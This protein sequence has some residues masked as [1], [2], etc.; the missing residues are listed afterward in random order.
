MEQ[1]TDGPGY[2]VTFDVFSALINSRAG[3]SAFFAELAS[4]RSWTCS[5]TEVYD[6]WDSRNKELQ[7]H[8]GGWRS[9]AELA[10]IALADAYLEVGA[11]GDPGE[12]CP[13]LLS[14]MATWPLWP[15][16]R[17]APSQLWGR[18]RAGLL[19]NIDDALLRPTA[20]MQLSMIDPH[21]VLT[22]QTLRRY[23]PS[24]EFYGNARSR[25]GAFVHVASSARDVRGALEAGVPCVRLVRPGHTIDPAG[26]TPAQV[27]RSFAEL[28]L[29]VRAAARG[30][31]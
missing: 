17:T 16:V 13:R 28:P 27:A 24:P 29:A 21:L 7:R 2:T 8:G 19:S 26:P 4:S 20:A 23:K 18:H 6:R 30:L 11:A 5:P 1:L 31:R 15:D 12:D 22:S 3:G 25:L 10:Q 14:S 9:Y